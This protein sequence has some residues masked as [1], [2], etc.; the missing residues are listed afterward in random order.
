MP[1]RSALSIT[2]RAAAFPVW[3]SRRSAVPI[4]GK[5]YLVYCSFCHGE[6][7]TTGAPGDIR[8]LSHPIFDRAL[9]GIE[10]MPEFGYVT[11]EEIAAITEGSGSARRRRPV[12]HLPRD[13]RLIQYAK[14]Q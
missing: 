10:R 13:A 4:S 7:A 6:D 14:Y 8:G 3:P 9:R 5:I 1:A 11:A 12:T 2:A